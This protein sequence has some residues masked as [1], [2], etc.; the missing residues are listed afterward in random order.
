LFIFKF[1]I[2]KKEKIVSRQWFKNLGSKILR[3]KEPKN[4]YKII[5]NK[6]LNDKDWPYMGTSTFTN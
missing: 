5:K 3:K 2:F 1:Y 4:R 6:V